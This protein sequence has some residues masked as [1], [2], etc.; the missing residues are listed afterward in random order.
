MVTIS[1]NRLGGLFFVVAPVTMTAIFF[2]FTFILG[3][4]GSGIEPGDF[5][6]LADARAS[7]PLV[8]ELVLSFIPIGYVLILYGMTVLYRQIK[9]SGTGEALFQFGILLFAIEVFCQTVG[10]GLWHATG[11][12]GAAGASLSAANNGITLFAGA[13]GALGGVLSSLVLANNDGYNRLFAS[14]GAVVLLALFVIRLVS[15]LD[16]S[17]WSVALPIQGLCFIILSSWFVTLGLGLLKK[18]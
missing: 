14:I 12:Q 16:V 4:S 10:F 18:G 7:T 6:A 5:R 1:A 2:V 9:A 3:G 15:I 8:N 13:V 11:W 17:V